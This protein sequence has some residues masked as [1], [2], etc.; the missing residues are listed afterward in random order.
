VSKLSGDSTRPIRLFAEVASSQDVSIEEIEDE[1][2]DCW[3]TDLHDV[4]CEVGP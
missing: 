2:V 4:K 3:A 1:S